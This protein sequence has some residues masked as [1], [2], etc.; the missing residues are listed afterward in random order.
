MRTNSPLS[1]K[2]KSTDKNGPVGFGLPCQ[3]FLAGHHPAGRLQG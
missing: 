1:V 3:I 2:F